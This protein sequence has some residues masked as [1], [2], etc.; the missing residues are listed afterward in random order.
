ML[1]LFFR[2][3]VHCITYHFWIL[4]YIYVLHF[5][6]ENLGGGRM[7]QILFLNKTNFKNNLANRVC[8]MVY[9]FYLN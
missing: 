8:F 2:L 5:W 1:K 6:I 3:T 7:Y 4:N 9:E